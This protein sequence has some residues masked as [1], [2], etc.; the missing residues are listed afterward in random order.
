MAN[1]GARPPPT[2]ELTKLREPAT[3]ARTMRSQRADTVQFRYA[4]R[5]DSLVDTADSADPA[6]PPSAGATGRNDVIDALKYFAIALVI[7]THVLRLRAEFIELSPELL[8]TI[9]SFNLP[10]FTF[11]SGWVLW[12]REGKSPVRFMRGKVL[13][14]LVPYFA[15][16]AVEMP[17]RHVRPSGYLARLWE[18]ALTPMAGM[19]MW[20]L[21]ALFCMFAV[22]TVG[23]LV[24]RSDW[25]TAALALGVGSIALFI[26]G[27]AN[28]LNRVVWLYPYL[29]LGYLIARHRASAAPVRRAGDRCRSHGVR[30]PERDWERARCRCSSPPGSPARLPPAASS[31]SCRP[32]ATRALAPLGRRTLG[33]YGAQMVVFRFLIVGQGWPGALASWAIVLAAST[34]VAFALERFAVTR[35]V[36][37]GQWPRKVAE[38]N[39]RRGARVVSA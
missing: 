4:S 21:W 39:R 30:G 31:G 16:I 3:S 27:G 32:T 33:V 14:L 29:A 9:V 24:S 36:F 13:G 25:W 28:G 15:W 8:R 37:L 5:M 11:L 38:A 20:F 6:P 26:P 7:L 10:L 19:Q 35:A 22:F 34:A 18:A 1:A 12:G 2:R 17:L 23:R